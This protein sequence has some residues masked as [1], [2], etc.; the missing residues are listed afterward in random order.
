MLKPKGI[1]E[2]FR[3]GNLFDLLMLIEIYNRETHTSLHL[4]SKKI[5]KLRK[6]EPESVSGA[7]YPSMWH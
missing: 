4:Y 6:E 5:Q 7:H 3:P 2:N 1:M